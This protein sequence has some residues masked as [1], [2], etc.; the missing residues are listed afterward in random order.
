MQDLKD[1]I[2]EYFNRKDFVPQGFDK[3]VNVFKVSES[4]L[5]NSL[6]ELE[7]EFI[8][9]KSKKGHYNLLVQNNISVGTI[10]I[11]EKG[12]GFI[13]D[14]NSDTIYYVDKVDVKD[15]FSHDTVLFAKYK[16]LG[17]EDEKPEAKV[18]EVL[19]RY[20]ER[21]V[22]EVYSTKKGKLNFK[23]NLANVLFEVTDFNSANDGDLVV[24][25]IDKYGHNYACGHIEKVIGKASD[26][27]AMYKELALK[28]DFHYEFSD[29]VI[30]E[31]NKLEYIDD[32]RKFIDKIIFTIDGDDA[33]DFDDAV[34]IEK[35]DNGNYLLGVYI[36][37]VASYV[38]ENGAIDQ[39]AFFRGTSVY[40]PNA[41]IPMLPEKL[42]NDLCS[43]KE[44]ELKR[45]VACLMEI[46]K[47]GSVQEYDIKLATIK[48]CHRLTYNIVNEIFDGNQELIT[49]YNDVYSSLAMMN[50]L[51]SLLYE[52]RVRRGSLDFEAN[53]SIVVFN[54]NQAK[55][56]I[57]KERKD[58]ENLIEEFML[59]ANETIASHIYHMDLPFIYRIHEEP[60]LNN[61]R[62]LINLLA[63]LGIKT[64]VNLHHISNFDLQKV[65]ADTKDNPAIQN[66]VLRLMCK[67]RYSEIN[68]GHFGLASPI[69]THFTSPI[70]RYPDLIVHRLLHQYVFNHDL[71]VDALKRDMDICVKASVQSSKKE[72]DA[73]SFE[74]E[75]K[76]RI[77]A[78]LYENLV[79]YEYSGVIASVTNY[80][81]FVILDNLV[82]GLV[83]ISRLAGYYFYD[84]ASSSLIDSLNKKKRYTIGQRVKVAVN[85]ASGATGQID[86]IIVQ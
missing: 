76:D 7:N 51:R 26:N 53:E 69:Y 73:I 64:H 10:D 1:K 52:K 49:K 72:K 65:L 34:S 43:L 63:G 75:A 81:F 57:V 31:A 78:K 41:V 4:E 13:K 27:D 21:I 3:L 6:T 37:D 40:L 2:I 84:E 29:D 71:S 59:I 85:S 14:L 55:D 77:I 60:P 30:K 83:H 36:A 19:K 45:V 16:Y 68:S 38:K 79:G 58:S 70:R 22:G 62:K 11:K 67:A 80:G 47:F 44:N 86:F 46:D 42:C 33:K 8:I 66:L 54:D 20:Y 50:K 12:Y 56:V 25:H 32:G 5:K 9:R 28:Y 39:E 23:A 17:I 15:A 35:L 61:Y 82:E 74:Y 48:S 24:L 18:I